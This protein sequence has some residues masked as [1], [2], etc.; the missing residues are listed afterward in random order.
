MVTIRDISNKCGFS[1]ASVSKALNGL[2]GIS[3]ATRKTIQKTAEEMGYFPNSNARALRTNRTYNLGV[4]F[5]DDNQSG[6]THHHFAPVL[7]SFKVTAESRGYDITFINHNINNPPM[8]YLEHCRYRN[9]D[10]VCIACVDFNES[11]IFQL[12]QSDIPVVTLDHAFSNRI[13]IESENLLGMR[14]LV[15]YAYKMGHRK[16]AYVH[17]RSSAVNEKRVTSFCETMRDLGLD[18]PPEYLVSAKYTDPLSTYQAVEAVLAL[19]DR[20]TCILMP[21]DFAALGGIDAIKKAG[22]R[23]PEDLSV[24]GYDGIDLSQ[25]ITPKLTTIRQDTRK[26]GSEAAEQLISLIETPLAP[27]EKEILIQVFLIEGESI[28]NINT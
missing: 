19:P 27:F 3:D 26:L 23:I 25:V 11:E 5:V 16:I 12:I 14:D 13:C 7:D 28:K 18:V 4:L 6:L 1:V 8:T 21:D 10:G 20:P 22:L 17:G 15:Q 2:G 24:A 9:V